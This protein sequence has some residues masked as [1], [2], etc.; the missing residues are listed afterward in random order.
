[1]QALGILFDRQTST[2]LLTS[3]SSHNDRPSTVLTPLHTQASTSH[4]DDS[5]INEKFSET[6]PDASTVLT[7]EAMH[8]SIELEEAVDI[9]LNHGNENSGKSNVMYM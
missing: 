7:Q 2:E 3:R 4:D 6:F 5:L 9:L 1:M 8:D